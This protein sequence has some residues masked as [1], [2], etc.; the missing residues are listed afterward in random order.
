MTSLN[1]KR[2]GVRSDNV[3]K[4]KSSSAG[5]RQTTNRRI[6][7]TR[8][9][10]MSSDEENDDEEVGGGNTAVAAASAKN[11]NNIA[12]IQAKNKELEAEIELL[13]EKDKDWEALHAGNV[14]V[15][16]QLRERVATLNKI[17]SKWHKDTYS[18]YRIMVVLILQWKWTP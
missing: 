14:G 17:V 15:I 1:R 13:N 7:I 6:E 5:R 3:G 2:P 8:Q 18:K 16:S 12:V 9:E 11:N 4:S 10:L